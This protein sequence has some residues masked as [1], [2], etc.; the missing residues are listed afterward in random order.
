M[1]KRREERYFRRYFRIQF[2]FKT[3]RNFNPPFNSVAFSCHSAK[4]D[5]STVKGTKFFC[6][7]SGKNTASTSLCSCYVLIC[8]VTNFASSQ[9]AFFKRRRFTFFF[10]IKVKLC[11][12]HVSVNDADISKAKHA[13]SDSACNIDIVKM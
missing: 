7:T 4:P 13:H 9:N 3:T 10:F 5:R 11:G 6:D 1:E 12:V 8:Y 2:L